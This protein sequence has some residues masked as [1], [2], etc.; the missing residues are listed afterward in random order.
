MWNPPGKRP[1]ERREVDGRIRSFKMSDREVGCFAGG[2]ELM[3]NCD[4]ESSAFYQRF[5]VFS[6]SLSVRMIKQY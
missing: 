1:F 4:V 6:L 3:S 2:M 5:A